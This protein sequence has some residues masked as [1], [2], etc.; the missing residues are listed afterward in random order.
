MTLGLKGWLEKLADKPAPI[1]EH[2]RDSALALL[3][4]ERKSSAEC[5]PII[6]ADPG[7]AA[8]LFRG[9]NVKRVKNNRLALTTVNTLVSLL[10]VKQLTDQIRGM[11]TFEE[12]DLPD[13][14]R[15]GIERCI[16]QS[17]Y[18]VQF[19][20]QWVT[21]RDAR[22]PE[23]VRIAASLQFLPELMLWAYGEEVMPAIEHYA[24]YECKNYYKEVERA[25]GCHRREIGAALAE[26]WELPE[27]VGFGFTSDYN[28][29]THGTAVALAALLARLVQHGWYGEDMHFF[30]KKAMHYFGEQENTAAKH[31]HQQVLKM[32][33]EELTHGYRPV[34]SLLVASDANK[35]PE[36][37]YRFSA[38][39]KKPQA[40]SVTQAEKVAAAS[41][42][43]KSAAKP[44]AEAEQ[45]KVMADVEGDEQRAKVLADVTALK[46]SIQA[47]AT[48]DVLLKQTLES[49]NQTVGLRRV[50]F[51]LLNPAKDKAESK[52][53]RFSVGADHAT[54]KLVVTVQPANLFTH[55]LKK[56]QAFWLNAD[57]YDKYWSMIAGT[58]KTVI[59]VNSF[60]AAAIFYGDKPLGIIY[61]DSEDAGITADQFKYFQQLTTLLNKGLAVLVKNKK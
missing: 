3:T 5:I 12:L 18:G 8:N 23:E 28:T 54:T 26:R 40:E 46:Q 47:Q 48:V 35:Y 37:G 36:A 15:Q 4:D 21:D 32:T 59:Q 45:K 1:L 39:E 50:N 13:I 57:N 2:S 52:I 6:L 20:T 56:P 30:L 33:A 7:M 53:A 9:T 25:L 58:V 44:L 43:Q 22:E 31:L 24:Y 19:A 17:W 11:T 27:I 55:L 29:Y 34:A 10:G 16:K 41:V 49:L 60:V 38:L 42:E 14:N 51:L 61:A